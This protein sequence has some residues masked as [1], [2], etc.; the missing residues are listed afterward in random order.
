LKLVS[1]VPAKPEVELASFEQ[2]REHFARQNWHAPS[3]LLNIVSD[4]QGN[5]VGATGSSRDISNEAD[6]QALIGY[7]MAADGILTTAKTART[8]AYRRSRFAPLALVSTSGDFSGI[9]AVEIESA[10]PID[11][12]VFLLVRRGLVRKTA[13]RY[14]S[15]WVQVCSVGRGSSFGLSFR[16]TRLGWRRI[17]VEAGPSFANWMF[18][19]HLIRGLALSIV[20]SK[21]TNPLIASKPALD[22][23]GVTG[24]SL[25]SAQVVDGTFF[26]RWT[27]ISAT[28]RS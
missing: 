17:L 9:P 23:L 13:K 22:N 14:N 6:Y 20:G 11:S 2:L 5:F 16:L 24:A 3:F 4:A 21:E 1:L 28:T 8:E 15:P 7:R 25:E 19:N 26:T 18:A 27:D 12:K 10:G